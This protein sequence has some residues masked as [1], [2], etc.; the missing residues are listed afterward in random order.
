MSLIELC[1]RAGAT[2]KD[3]CALAALIDQL[4]EAHDTATVAR[5]QTLL[6]PKSA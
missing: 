4:P 2:A 5:A 1:G 3:R 6:G